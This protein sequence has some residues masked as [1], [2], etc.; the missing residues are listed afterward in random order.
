MFGLW[1]LVIGACAWLIWTH[2]AVG[3]V[4][5]LTEHDVD[6]EIDDHEYRER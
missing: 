3:L 6:G 5:R 2:W 4:D 1:V